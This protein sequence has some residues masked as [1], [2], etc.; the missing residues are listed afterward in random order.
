MA[1]SEFHVRTRVC[2]LVGMIVLCLS[3]GLGASVHAADEPTPTG[4]VAPIVVTAP[5]GSAIGGVEPILELPS[6]ELDAYGAD[7]LTELLD[8]LEPMTRSSRSNRAAI[9]LINGR[10]A[11]RIELQNLIPE[12]IER[13]QI[14]P[15]TV[16]LQY[17][18][19]E[20]Q[21]VVN[22]ILR[23]HFSAVPIH[24]VYST[25]TDGGATTG[26]VSVSVVHFEDEARVTLMASYKDAAWLRQS[27]RGIN[28]P[29]SYYRT[30]E[31]KTTDEKLA[32]TLSSGILGI[33]ASL[34]AS[35]NV[36]N[37]ESLQGLAGENGAGIVLPVPR[38]LAE[39]SPQATAQLDGALTGQIFHFVWDASVTYE[40]AASRANSETGIDSLGNTLVDRTDSAYNATRVQL[41][42]SGPISFLPAGPIIANVKAVSQYQAIDSRSTLPGS[43]AE[44]SALSRT[45]DSGY[46]NVRVPI[47]NH[48]R[49]VLPALGDLG[50]TLNATV[51]DISDFGTLFSLSAGIDWTPRATV[52]FDAIF[53]DRKTAPTLQQL[54]GPPI[55]TPNVEMFDFVTGRTAYA[56]EITGG[57]SSLSSSYY[58]LTSLGLLL[59]PYF[60]KS[61]FSSHFE[62]SRIRDAI[63]PLPPDTSD[64]ELAFPERFIRDDDGNLVEVDDRWVNLAREVSDDMKT[65]CSIWVPIGASPSVGLSRASESVPNR[66]EISLIDTWYLR[67]TTLVRNGVPILNLLNGA[68]AGAT[69]GQPRQKVEFGA[70]AYAFGV[71]GSINANWRG[72]TVVGGAGSSS[73]I[74]F[75]SL[76]TVDA[77]L[78]A[79]FDR[80]SGME[81][82]GWAQGFRVSLAVVNVLD[83]R[84]GVHIADG[85]TPVAF[86]PG[87]LD[88]LG[89]TLTF[90]FRKVF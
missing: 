41:S 15:E 75:S 56:T 9:I 70:L 30:L 62:D 34:G 31:P 29:D 36:V 2:R 5:R 40:Q 17:G 43:A 8:A 61:L 11:G 14:L 21:R 55:Y 33:S 38:P 45:M 20:S 42:L 59:G 54:S 52:H 90:T 3:S 63:G 26:S 19:S 32:G 44:S 22:F 37:S 12:A 50:A 89:R 6:S 68:P 85:V 47:A 24:S 51:D 58:R 66:V 65:G 86:E 16:A 27:D 23:A 28:A 80:M 69:G 48:D 35:L 25:T 64:V 72:P 71:G 7:T 18:F 87:Y 67:D 49:G 76:A 78:F 74:V 77:R 57:D 79:E 10:L 83:N 1:L 73:P 39:T 82:S 84:Q 4:A 46:F 13:V 81:Q 60:G 88:A 53:T